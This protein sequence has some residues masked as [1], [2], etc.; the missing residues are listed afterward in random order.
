MSEL[1]A[2]AP[3]DTPVTPTP[4]PDQTSPTPVTPDQTTPDPILATSDPTP[5]TQ[6]QTP[7]PTPEKP[8]EGKW[9]DDWREA[10]AGGDEK[11]LKQ[12]QRYSDPM[13]FANKTFALEAKLTSGDYKRQSP[14]ENAT[15]E[16][17]LEWRREQ[18]LPDKPED[19]KPELPNGMILGEHDQA[20]LANFQKFAF[21][22][23]LSPDAL[24]KTLSWYFAEQDR[25]AKVQQITDQDFHES[26]KDMLMSEWGLKNYRSNLSAMAAVRDQMPAGLG[27]RILAGRTADGRLIGDDPQFLQWFASVARELNPAASVISQDSGKSVEGEL[28][29]IR[30]LRRADPDK[31]DQDKQ[32]QARERELLDAQIRLRGRK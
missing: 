4:T 30:N 26:A 11:R 13:A 1:L 8:V 10:L 15:P 19:Y 17:V 3:L 31:Y 5:P 14:P 27:D 16:E 12:L 20:T 23:N 29:Q 6:P 24:N 7:D 18:G 21:D 9:R 22:N 25:V 2:Q 28:E 32:M